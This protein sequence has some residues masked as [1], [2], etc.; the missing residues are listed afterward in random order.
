MHRFQ[1]IFYTDDGSEPVHIF[2][3][4]TCTGDGITMAVAAGAA[5]L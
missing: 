4:A 1:P 3:C 2:T 5:T